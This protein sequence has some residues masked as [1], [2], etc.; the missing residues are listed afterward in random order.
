MRLGSAPDTGV[1]TRGPGGGAPATFMEA[2]GT[3]VR[4]PNQFN[5]AML[6][7]KREGGG[8]RPAIRSWCD[9]AS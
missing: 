4:P 3:A 8:F 7:A 6:G 5:G 1:D 2:A 9:R